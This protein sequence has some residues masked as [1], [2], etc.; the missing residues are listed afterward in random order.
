MEGIL[1]G[2]NLRCFLKLAGTP[3]FPDL[4]GKILFL[5]SL[6]GGPELLASLLSQLGQLGVFQKI[7]GLLFRHL[8]RA[9]KESGQ[10]R[11]SETA[12]QAGDSPKSAHRR[13]P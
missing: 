6:G 4:T 2:G 12:G 9:G 5:E 3:Y 10:S 1:A 11:H 8:Y 7:S 13:D